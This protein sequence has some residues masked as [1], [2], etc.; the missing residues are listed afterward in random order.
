VDLGDIA[1]ALK[2]EP[3]YLWEANYE[4]SGDGSFEESIAMAFPDVVSQ[5]KRISTDHDPLFRFH[6]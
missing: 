4:S 6:R 3:E 1:R 5:P 2:I